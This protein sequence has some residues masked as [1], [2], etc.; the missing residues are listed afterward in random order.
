MYAKL[1]RSIY[2]GSLATRGPWEALVTF[3]Q[4][5]ILADR[6]GAVDMTA[7]Y[8]A[9]E[10]TI[11]IEVITKGLAE[12]EKPDVDSRRPEEQGKRITRLDPA[13]PWGWQITNYE[14][15]RNLK[16]A[17]GRREYDREYKAKKREEARLRAALAEGKAPSAN[18]TFSAPDWIPIEPWRGW[19]EMRNKSKKTRPTQRALTLAVKKLE[20]LKAEGHD[21]SAILDQSTMNGWTDLYPIKKSNGSMP[22]AGP[23]PD[24]KIKCRKCGDRVSSHTNFICDPCYAAR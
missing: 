14:Y 15:Y 16:R 13:R 9:K 1:F 22:H 7:E 23:I 24:G 18:A 4:M 19:I 3:Q 21:L 6:T 5:L 20:T 2:S 12:L 10:S 8:I 11:P 17:E